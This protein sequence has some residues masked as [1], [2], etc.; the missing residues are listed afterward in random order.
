MSLLICALAG[1]A[2]AQE[3]SRFT[4]VAITAGQTAQVIATNGG[5]RS[6]LACHI[7][8]VFADRDG[9]RIGDPSSM[10][11]V[12]A[13][14]SFAATSI[15]HPNLLPGERFHVRAVVSRFKDKTIE[16]GECDELRA[17]MEVFDTATGKTTLSWEL[18]SN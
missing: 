1:P 14:G 17:R 10:A 18:P 8:I 15:N 7:E 16:R 12:L 4:V 6:P 5:G 11:F 2:A 3:T 9:N 13:P